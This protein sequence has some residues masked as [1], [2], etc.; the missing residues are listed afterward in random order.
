ME[1]IQPTCTW[2]LFGG[3]VKVVAYGAEHNWNYASASETADGVHL[4]EVWHRTEE[5]MGS[6]RNEYTPNLRVL[7]PRPAFNAQVCRPRDLTTA[8]IPNLFYRGV[9]ADAVV[10]ERS[11]QAYALASADCA[12]VL[13]RNPA[14]GEVAACHAGRD[15][16]LDKQ[17]VLNPKGHPRSFESIVDAACMSLSSNEQDWYDFQ[18][19]VGMAIGPDHFAHP[20]NH[21]TY[22]D[23]NR[24]LIEHLSNCWGESV[25]KGGVDLGKIDLVELI[26][27]Q[28]IMLGFSESNISFDGVDTFADEGEDGQPIWHSNR[29]DKTTRNL[30]VALRLL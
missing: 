19:H 10:L 5:L 4:P 20:W 2:D 28:L 22:G 25:V 3:A 13:I 15:S 16:L 21:P 24:R 1:D 14:T 23:S 30:V 8:W 11:G 12:M 9:D 7:A 18:A 27:L 29:R 6:L 17:Y 26:R